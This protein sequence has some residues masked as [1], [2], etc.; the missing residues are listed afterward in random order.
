MGEN[1]RICDISKAE[2]RALRDARSI[3]REAERRAEMGENNSTLTRELWTPVKNGAVEILDHHAQDIEVGAWLIESLTRLEGYAGL[4]AA[5]ERVGE[6]IRTHNTALHPQPED[7]DDIP[8]Q[9]LAGLN[10]MGREG[11]LVQPLRLLS[12]IPAQPYG[13]NTLWDATGGNRTEQVQQIMLSLPPEQMAAHFGEIQAA[14]AAI[15]QCDAAASA[16]LG[17][18]APPFAK[19]LE[20]LDETERT[21]RRL[22]N[23]EEQIAPPE[24][25]EAATPVSAPPPTANPAARAEITS[26]EQAFEELLRIA[27]YFRKAEPHSPISHSIETLVSRGR[28][29]FLTLLKELIPDAHQREAVMTTAG[30]RDPHTI[31]EP[32]R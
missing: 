10:G 24:E 17:A 21:V 30:I 16:C 23:L 6:M 14:R 7:A 31:E 5:F 20:I 18:D 26:R 4:R 11:S 19:L 8:F 2:Y 28:M 27:R 25:E 9:A 1:P 12:L 29:D 3:A 15:A 22:A 13:E 32:P